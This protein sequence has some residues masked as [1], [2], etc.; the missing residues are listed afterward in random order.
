[1]ATGH[2]FFTVVVSTSLSLSSV[3]ALARFSL[4]NSVNFRVESSGITDLASI[5]P[6]ARPGL[7]PEGSCAAWGF[8]WRTLLLQASNHLPPSVS[9]ICL[10]FCLCAYKVSEKV[11]A[12]LRFLLLSPPPPWLPKGWVYFCGPSSTITWKSALSPSRKPHPILESVPA[13]L[14]LK[15]CKQGGR[16]YLSSVRECWSRLLTGWLEFHP[17]L[18][19]SEPLKSKSRL[20]LMKTH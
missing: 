12:V 13:S 5:S 11:S 8:F 20:Q 19:K 18:S 15:W 1:M 7:A 16:D 14:D 4:Y 17:G 2:S 10:S 9:E 3:V 6:R